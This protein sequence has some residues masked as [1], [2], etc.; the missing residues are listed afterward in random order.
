MVNR[1]RFTPRCDCFRTWLKHALLWAVGCRGSQFAVINCSC[2]FRDALLNYSQF[3]AYC[4]CAFA[5]IMCGF[6]DLFL[7][8]LS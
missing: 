3:M 1:C 6:W 7:V 2:L 5:F 4:Y 8:L